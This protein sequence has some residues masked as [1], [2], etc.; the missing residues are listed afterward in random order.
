WV[1]FTEK[2]AQG[3]LYSLSFVKG[4]DAISKN[5]P[6][7]TYFKDIELVYNPVIADFEANVTNICQGESVTFTDISTGATSWSWDFGDGA[8]PASATTQGPH[9]VT[10]NTNGPKTVSLTINELVTETKD[11]YIT[12]SPAPVADFTYSADN[13]TVQFTNNSTNANGFVWDFGDGN[14]SSDNNPVH[15]YA[16][17][18]TYNVSLTANYLNCED[19][20]SQQVT[21]TLVGISNNITEQNIEIYPN[22]STGLIYIRNFE[23]DYEDISVYNSFG[24]QILDLEKEEIKELSGDYQ[25]N[26]SKYP[27]GIY[28]VVLS[29]EGERIIRKLVLK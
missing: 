18:G 17:E 28:Y 14:I 15:T 8:S 16:D 4:P 6:D 19:V 13:L 5:P 1:E 21:V 23:K 27:A 3:P 26:L 12:V 24:L 2:H 20:T 10:Y 9:T 22:P 25:I 29:N 11:N 7:Q